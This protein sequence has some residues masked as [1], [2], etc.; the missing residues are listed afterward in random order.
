M[1]RF[2]AG[3]TLVE[4]MV[5]AGIVASLVMAAAPLATN[6]VYSSQ[7]HTGLTQ[8]VE[9][10]NLAKALALQNPTQA[11]LPAAS[12]GIKV[13]TDGTT[14]TVYVCTGSG[15][16]SGC[17]NG[18]ANVKWS[19]TYSGLVTTSFNGVAATTSTPVTLS[20]DNRGELLTATAFTLTRGGA[21]NNE[22]GTFY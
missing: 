22:S 8:L 20:I 1:R 19:T 17:V 11:V 16:G 15:A 21:S 7:T 12:A 10:F 4:L 5:T 6:W 13:T 9:A 18:G 3:F 14:T 2:S